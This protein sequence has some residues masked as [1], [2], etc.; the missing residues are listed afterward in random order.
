MHKYDEDA[1]GDAY[2][3]S[4]SFHTNE[5][6]GLN[7][8][9]SSED[10]L[11][12]SISDAI[13]KFQQEE[14]VAP[15]F[16]EYSSSSSQLDSLIYS[17]DSHNSSSQ[18]SIGESTPAA[19]MTPF[20]SR[21]ASLGFAPHDDSSSSMDSSAS[22]PASLFSDSMPLDYMSENSSDSWTSMP[23]TPMSMLGSPFQHHRSS[24]LASTPVSF[25]GSSRSA[26]QHY[27]ASASQHS[28]PYGPIGQV[29]RF[30]L[31]AA[32]PSA[33]LVSQD[34]NVENTSQLF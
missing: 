20:S 14:E 30:Q 1:N 17:F 10:D 4:P 29:P 31:P 11:I 2:G 13:Q 16:A 24:S 28:S 9:F 22:T 33:K 18:G 12:D 21:V 7:D 5:M 27:G 3:D 34:E 15:E 8:S 26:S 32:S 23:I 25:R 19:H 6:S